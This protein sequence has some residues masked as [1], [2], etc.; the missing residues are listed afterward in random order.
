MLIKYSAE[1]GLW[2]GIQQ[3]FDGMH[4]CPLCLAIQR[5]QQADHPTDQLASTTPE[6]RLLASTPAGQDFVPAADLMGDFFFACTVT[7]GTHRNRPPVPPP[8]SI[9][10]CIS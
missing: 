4:P 3:T 6:V 1:S 5:A 9:N 8:R 10:S 2:T 7:L